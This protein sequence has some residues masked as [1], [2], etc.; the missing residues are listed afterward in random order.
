MTTTPPDPP[1]RPRLTLHS[2]SRSAWFQPLAAV[3]LGLVFLLVAT[4][5]GH[6]SAGVL[7][8]GVLTAFGVLLRLGGRSDTIRGLRGDGR[9]ERFVLLRLKAGNVAGRVVI[10]AVVIASLV[11]VAEGHTATPYSWL[12]AL[13]GATFLVTIGLLQWRS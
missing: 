13:A 10:L 7:G 12:S 9:D 11:R 8:F 6:N 4:L 2:V 5:G 3:L 1:T